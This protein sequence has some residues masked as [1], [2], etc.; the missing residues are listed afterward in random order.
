MKYILFFLNSNFKIFTSKI[1]LKIKVIN[2]I[3]LCIILIILL[4]IFYL[5]FC[6]YF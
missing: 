6:V 1:A 2:N 3:Q 5:N 4:L